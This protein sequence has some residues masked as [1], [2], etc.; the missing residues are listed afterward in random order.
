[1]FSYLSCHVASHMGHT[2]AHT[3]THN[4]IHPATVGYLTDDWS[5]L[6]NGS[7]TTLQLHRV[8]NSSP[9]THVECL[10][11]LHLPLLGATTKLHTHSPGEGSLQKN[12]YASARDRW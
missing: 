3:R 11:R 2:R 5:K 1:M 4:H 12:S 8:N 9:G 7:S 10:P 6:T